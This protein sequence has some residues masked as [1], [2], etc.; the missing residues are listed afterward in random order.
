MRDIN[1]MHPALLD[2]YL[3]FAAKMEK[4]HLPFI[5]TCTLRTEA[6]HRA[7]WAQGREYLHIVNELRE[8][9]GWAP[10]T[11][12]ENQKKVTWTKNSLHLADENGL[13]RAFD[14]ALIFPGKKHPHWDGKVSVNSN[15]IPDYNE[16]A[17][18]AREVGLQPGIDFKDPCHFQLA[19]I[20]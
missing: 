14:I 5:I 18:Y 20:A 8:I 2:R 6:E 4:H 3:L 7:L 19:S 16:A 13:S 11:L 9:V 1:L 10:I 15:E 12:E 17:I